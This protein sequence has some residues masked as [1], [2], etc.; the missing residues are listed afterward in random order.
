[1]SR[2]IINNKIEIRKIIIEALDSIKKT[3]PQDI[4]NIL[5]IS[6]NM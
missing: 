1:M 4:V 3:I 2:N 6:N 5:A